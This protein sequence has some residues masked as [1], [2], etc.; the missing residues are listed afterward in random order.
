V[1]DAPYKAVLLFGAPGCG[2]GTQGELLGR[3]PGFHHFSMGDAFRGIDPDSDLG[4]TVKEYSSRGD[5]VP[6]DITARL[7]ESSL[8]ALVAE[9]AYRPN[10]E[11][12]VLDGF[13][14]NPNQVG[15]L[16]GLVDVLAI[17]HLQCDDQGELVQRLRKRALKQGRADDAKEEVVLRRLRIYEEST[18]PVLARYPAGDIHVVNPLGSPAEVLARVLAVLAPM[19]AIR[20]GNILA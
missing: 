1:A 8:K 4:R 7:L 3:I 5:L 16:E 11:M 2:K 14:R 6:D 15:L 19:Q 18:Q 20:F 12:L 9:E 10:A 17:V 13:P